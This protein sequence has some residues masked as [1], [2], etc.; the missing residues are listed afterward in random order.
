MSK[1]W[2]VIGYSALVLAT[3]PVPTTVAGSPVEAPVAEA[4]MRGDNETV[5][6]L[7][8]GGADVNAARGDGMTA[9][10]WA[11]LNDDTD[12]IS[13]LVYAGAALE[14]TTRLGGYTPLHLASREG[15]ALAVARLLTVG[16]R[17]ETLTSSGAS[18]IH[19]AAQSGNTEAIR[20]LLEHGADVD[21]RDARADRTPLIFATAR[22]RTAAVE[23]LLGAG[24]DVTLASRVVDYQERS[25]ADSV[26]RRR[27]QRLVDAAKEPQKDE[28]TEEPESSAVVPDEPDTPTAVPGV[29]SPEEPDLPEQ[30]A[31][32]EPDEPEDPDEPEEPERLSHDDL[33]GAQ[34]GMTAL[35]YAARDGRTDVAALLLEAGADVNQPTVGDGS[36][37]LLVAIINGNFDLAMMLL[38]VGGDPN[39]FS[40]DG[41]G[42]LFATINNE[43]ALRTWYP[44]PTA[45][46]Q[47]N[48]SYLEL[49][50]AL[51]HAG[52]DP[53]ARVN[54][55]V[56]YAAYNAG[57]MGVDFS[58][59][60][61]FWRAA[62]SL[63]VTAMR[64]L[65]EVG[66]DPD[67][68]TQK[69][70][71]RRRRDDDEEVEV[72]KSGLSPVPVGGPAVHPL[73]AASGVGYGTS[74]VGQQHRFVHAGWVPAVK[75][76]VEELGVDVNLRDHE[77]YSALHNAAARGDN[78]LVEY[79]VSK[80]ADI[81][82]VG[83]KGQTTVDMANSP[84]QR[85]QPYP[86]TVALLETLG[87]VN[88]HDCSACD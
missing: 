29:Q 33:V 68:R 9:L 11:A 57:R 23:S 60:T 76:L 43:W 3:V 59:A 32:D 51:L 4:A 27:R 83:R 7:L 56:W 41:V 86:E 28:E 61:A 54:T 35:A 88:N 15:R 71:Q 82:V 77:G 46:K 50:D 64:M 45:S 13:V 44:Q 62:Y 19:L 18:A 47:Q 70:P 58:G 5:R 72:D 34:G 21:A 84:H 40:E 78:E 48:T 31:V 63:D 39:L 12:L 42:P 37:P 81:M 25:E 1:R 26:A 36:T 79:L 52:A 24:A 55:H 49:M 14:P 74:R 66:A 80:G 67:I 17:S 75:Y 10:H 73:H 16:S 2:V 69:P 38:G 20:A 53:D 65:I 87:A 8:R 30:A 85:V 6:S 22:G